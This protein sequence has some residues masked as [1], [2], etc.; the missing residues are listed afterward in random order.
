MYQIRNTIKIQ[1]SIKHVV[2]P[3][4]RAIKFAHVR[5]IRNSV[6]EKLDISIFK[7]KNL[8]II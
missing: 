5:K 7:R 4:W 6:L 8:Q 1:H 3:T 2:S